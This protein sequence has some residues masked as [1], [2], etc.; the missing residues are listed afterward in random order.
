MTDLSVRVSGGFGTDYPEMSPGLRA[1]VAQADA[2]HDAESARAERAHRARWEAA[3]ERAVD[4][5][6]WQ[7]AREQG[8]PLHEA[9]RSVGHTPAEFVALASARQDLEDAQRAARARQAL[10]HAGIDPDSGEPVEVP[11]PSELAVQGAARMMRP[12][13]SAA[14]V[15]RGVRTKW[16]RR[17]YR[18]IE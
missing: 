1:R 13:E 17:S 14:A 4:E 3:H 18:S 10:R 5:A 11:Q 6:A 2:E 12:G 9:R 16:L 7:L 15:G 8:L